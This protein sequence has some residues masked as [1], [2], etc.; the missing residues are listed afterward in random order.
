MATYFAK[1][2]ERY[3]TMAK[4]GFME[5][6]EKK[7]WSKLDR[8]HL[9]LLWLLE[10]LYRQTNHELLS[11]DF[12]VWIFA[13]CPVC[14]WCSIPAV[15]R[16]LWGWSLVS[17]QI[18]GGSWCDAAR[19]TGLIHWRDFFQWRGGQSTGEIAELWP[20]I[21][22][23]VPFERLTAGLPPG[24]SN[25]ARNRAVVGVV[26]SWAS[27]VHCA[28]TNL[29][30]QNGA[31][32]IFDRLAQNPRE[33]WRTWRSATRSLPSPCTGEARSLKPSMFARA[34]RWGGAGRASTR[35]W[36][37]SLRTSWST[38]SLGFWN[39]A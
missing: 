30:Q 4:Y 21:S 6:F 7:S 1:W 3:G 23:N 31:G 24:I 19:R 26:L 10:H 29:N 33:G 36:A 14:G 11:L 2:L 13:E 16:R 25:P 27:C 18:S 32:F 17:C 34:A 35:R 5:L 37:S 38:E 9:G 22:G 39:A 8:I 15:Q 28:G 12:V 20:Q